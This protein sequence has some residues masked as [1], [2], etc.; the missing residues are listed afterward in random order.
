MGLRRF[1][2]FCL[3]EGGEKS[4]RLRSHV[5]RPTF[6]K[7]IGHARKSVKNAVPL[8]VA[9]ELI[10]VRFLREGNFSKTSRNTAP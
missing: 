10:Q 9:F 5:A 4:G 2:A 6:R 1:A 8:T 7:E 3:R